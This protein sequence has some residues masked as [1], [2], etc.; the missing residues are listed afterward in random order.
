MAL[1]RRHRHRVRD[2]DRQCA[3]ARAVQRIGHH[4]R[5]VIEHRRVI[6]RLRVLLSPIHRVVVAHLTRGR[7]KAIEHQRAAR[8]LHRHRCRAAQTIELRQGQ[9]L[10]THLDARQTR[11]RRHCEGAADAGGI[12]LSQRVLTG[13]G[14]IALRGRDRRRTIGVTIDGDHHRRCRHITVRILHLIRER[15]RQRLIVIE[16]IDRRVGVVQHIAV[17]AV[18]IGRERAVLGSNVA[19]PAVEAH[20]TVERRV[21]GQRITVN[22][23]AAAVFHQR[24]ALTRR[25]RHRVRDQYPQLTRA[26]LAKRIHRSDIKHVDN[27]LIASLVVLRS[28]YRVLISNRANR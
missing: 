23:I 9:R 14:T 27:R 8:R 13:L 2:G 26:F 12:I 3:I 1:T 11:F 21:V 10:T 22:Q 19:L 15:L 20:R 7:I 4:N 24:M 5:D 17:C 6:V 18:G 16:R 25:H 28:F